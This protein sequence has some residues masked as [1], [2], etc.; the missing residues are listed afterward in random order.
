MSTTQVYALTVGISQYKNLRALRCATNDANDL[1]AVFRAGAIPCQIRQLLDEAATKDSILKELA[2]AADSAGSDDTAIVFFSGHGG[3]SSETDSRAYFCPVE[4]SSFRLDETCL[5]SSELTNALR[6]IRSKRLVVLLDTCFSGGLGEPRSA[7]TGIRV[8]LTA[9]DVGTLVEGQG[10]IIL[11]ASRPD[12]PAWELG[13]MR[14]GLFTNYVLRAL[15]GE[16]A[17]ADGSVWASDLFSYVSR[18]V[19]HH[20]SQNP[21]QKAIGED[22]V[23]MVQ[24]NESNRLM[25]TPTVGPLELDQR[26]LRAA[27]RHAYNR[28]ELSLVCRD[29]GLSLADD[30]PGGTLETQLMYLI[31]HCHRHGMY[32]ELLKRLRLDRPA[33]SV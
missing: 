28:E 7:G 3:R 29:L 16:A 22:F 10:R 2:W 8:G 13:G 25:G 17:R 31:D 19:R 27:M 12:E 20:R 24:E 33:L 4:T 32:D 23:V 11:A 15:R 6:A 1:A 30:V 18:S 26:P 5:N 14:N 21:Y 9:H